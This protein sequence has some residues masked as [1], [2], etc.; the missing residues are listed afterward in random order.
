DPSDRKRAALAAILSSRQS[1]LRYLA[2]LLGM[3]PVPGERETPLED[4]TG[5]VVQEMVDGGA[6]R[7]ESASPGAV[8][9]VGARGRAG[10]VLACGRRPADLRAAAD[11][12]GRRG[13]P[14]GVPPDVGRGARGSAGPEAPMSAQRPDLGRILGGLKP[15]Q[16][17]TVDHA[18][19]RL[20]LDED[21]VDRFLV[22]DEV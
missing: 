14:C 16:R 20:W 10:P 4:P 22:A 9:A 11:A 19:G 1:V 3:D 2:L 8:R 17:A 5:L 18:F 13:D 6:S 15:F 7:G 21:A 12:A